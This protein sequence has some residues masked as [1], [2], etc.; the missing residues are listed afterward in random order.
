MSYPWVQHRAH[1]NARRGRVGLSDSSLQPVV[2]Y[3]NAPRHHTLQSAHSLPQCTGSALRDPMLECAWQVDLDKMLA[4]LEVTQPVPPKPHRKG[5]SVVLG[6]TDRALYCVS[7]IEYCGRWVHIHRTNGW[8]IPTTCWTGKC[9]DA[10]TSLLVSTRGVCAYDSALCCSSSTDFRY[11]Q[12][13]RNIVDRRCSK[14]SGRFLHRNCAH[15]CN[16]LCHELGVGEL[17]K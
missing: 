5:L 12:H 8:E 6:P 7:C 16:H 2:R 15:F 11:S 10:R 3:C 13:Q 17:P 4:G 9:S 14:G 1:S